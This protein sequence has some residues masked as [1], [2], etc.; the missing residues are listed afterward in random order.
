MTEP[1]ILKVAVNVPLSRLFDYL[2]PEGVQAPGPG[3]RVLVPF[4]RREQ[5]GLVMECGVDSD[6]PATKLKRCKAV[7]DDEPLLAE[8]DLQLIRFTGSYY[9]H[10]IGE[11]AAAALPTLLRAGKPLWP[12][13][14]F[15]AISDAGTS[16]DLETIAK[17]APRQMELMLCSAM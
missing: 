16:A 4:G 14:K 2:P 12:V 8:V 11:A 5:V 3:C 9:H 10:P 7:L 1:T 13:Q 15:V 6:L 17:R